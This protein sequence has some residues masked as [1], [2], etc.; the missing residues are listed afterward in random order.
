[1]YLARLPISPT[2]NI[3]YARCESSTKPLYEGAATWKRRGLRTALRV[4]GHLFGIPTLPDQG[5]RHAL[6]VQM[7]ALRVTPDDLALSFHL[8]PSCGLQIALLGL[9]V[10]RLGLGFVPPLSGIGHFVPPLAI[11]LAGLI[12]FEKRSRCFVSTTRS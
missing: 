9:F 12:F 3:W 7:S 4:L 6:R 10:Y 11:T 1:M 8:L 5:Y 2:Y